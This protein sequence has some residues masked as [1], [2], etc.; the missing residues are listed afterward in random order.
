MDKDKKSAAIKG[1]IVAFVIVLFLKIPI[2]SD[3]I[4]VMRVGMY[5]R[6]RLRLEREK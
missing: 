4:A 1:I 3:S 6:Q 2:V 5:G